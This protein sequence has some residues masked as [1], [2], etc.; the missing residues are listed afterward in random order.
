ME[1][2]Y[3]DRGKKDY[4]YLEHSVRETVSVYKVRKYL[5]SKLPL[6]LEDKKRL[7]YHE[8]FVKKWEKHLDQIKVAFLDHQKSL[9]KSVYEKELETFVIKFTY[10]TQRIEGSTLTLRETASLFQKG[11]T[12]RSK[13]LNDVKEAEAHRDVFYEMFNTN[14]NLCLQLVLLWHKKLLTCTKI[15]IAGKVRKYQVAIAGSK[16]MPP[17]PVEVDILL[18]DFFK[19]YNRNKK[20]LH[21]IELAALVHL[22]FVTIHPFG[23]GNGRVSRLLMNYVLKLNDFPFFSVPYVGR[24]SYYNAL[25]RAQVKKQEYIFVNWFVKR[26]VKEMQ[27]SLLIV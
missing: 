16:F 27:K 21:P 22:K 4:Y 20:K 26:Y 7:F 15:D 9:P 13:S 11:L 10:D 18:R 6:D 19:W 5:G 8:I 24:N 12:P 25:E 23:D 2:R 3:D 17:T 1:V 14:K